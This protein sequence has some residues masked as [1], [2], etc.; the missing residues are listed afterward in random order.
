[1]FCSSPKIGSLGFLV[2]HNSLHSRAGN[3][4]DAKTGSEKERDTAHS[5]MIMMSHI[6]QFE[7]CVGVYGGETGGWTCLHLC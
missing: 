3:L 7:L 6:R 4:V 5:S 2:L 1:M